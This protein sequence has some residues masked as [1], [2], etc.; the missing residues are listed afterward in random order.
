MAPRNAGTATNHSTGCVTHVAADPAAIDRLAAS[1]PGRS[2]DATVTGAVTV[3]DASG[4]SS[5]HTGASTTSVSTSAPRYDTS[6]R[7]GI[8]GFVLAAAAGLVL[9][10][11]VP[12]D[13]VVLG[14][15]VVGA[16]HVALEVR[17]VY[18]RHPTIL[19]GPLLVAANGVLVAIVAMRLVA[20]T[21]PSTARLEVLLLAGLVVAAALTRATPTGPTP[22][23]ATPT[24]APARR[25]WVVVAAVVVGAA[26]ALAVPGSWFVVQAHLHNLIPLA[27]LWL[28]AAEI[29]DPVR[30]RRFRTVCVGWAIVIPAVVLLGA[31]DPL[32]GSGGS[33]AATDLA[34][35]AAVTKGIAPASLGATWGTRLLAAFAFA[36]VLHYAT[37]CWFFPRHAPDATAAFEARLVG[38]HLR[39]LRLPILAAA[40]PAGVL[41]LALAEYRQGRTTYLSFASYHAYLEYPVLVAV[42]AGALATGTTPG[43][44]PTT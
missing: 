22:T 17:Y 2:T 27:F 35:G 32:L 24:S 30:R 20:G 38:R 12:L 8:V 14:I 29:S 16:V 25:R 33:A 5:A 18:G 37:W 26:V 43:K 3:G 15:L 42:A 1:V 6:A 9:A 39:G 23:S 34:E 19:S 40:A 10:T 36:Q 31:L 4:S 44:E 11:T 21:S 28:W 13:V 7:T 41:V